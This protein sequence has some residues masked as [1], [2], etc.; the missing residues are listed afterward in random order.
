M[1]L[2]RKILA[3][4]LWAG[5]GVGLMLAA[6]VGCDVSDDGRPPPD[7]SLF[8][9]TG[10][11]ADPSGNL[12]YVTNGNTDLRFN[13]GSLVAIDFAA[14]L[15]A[16][17]DGKC[18]A[19]D[20]VATNTP[21]CLESRPPGG[22]GLVLA[23]RTVRI[24]SFA[25]Q[26]AMQRFFVA[27]RDMSGQPLGRRRSCTPDMSGM[28]CDCTA[29]IDDPDCVPMLD[30]D[31]TQG[32][33]LLI[34]V[35]GEPSLTWVNVDASGHFVCGQGQS[36]VPACDGNHRITSFPNDDEN[37]LPP[38]PFGVAV[39]EGLGVA[40]MAHLAFGTI[41]LFDVGDAP[42]S[43]PR[44]AYT[45][46]ETFAPTSSGARGVYGLAFRPFEGSAVPA[47]NAC[48]PQPRCS[49]ADFS[50]LYASSR[51]SARTGLL[52]VRGAEECR[53]A[54]AGDTCAAAGR[55]LSLV[56]GPDVRIETILAD[57]ADLRDVKFS[58]DGKHA[59]VLSRRPPSLLDIDTSPGGPTAAEPRNVVRQIIEVCADP[60]LLT[61]REEP[62]PTRIYVTCFAAGQVYVVD[63]NLGDVVDVVDVGR[64]PNGFTLV[65]GRPLR[66][67]V[68]NFAENNL[69]V[70]DLE[71]GSPTE[72]VVLFKIGYPRLIM[73]A[74]R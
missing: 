69:S 38:E 46:A 56:R 29:A 70:I 42:T 48:A 52:L 33:R 39:H 35:R 19:R 32:V 26:P 54:L 22:L 51:F 8:F 68:A 53:P 23:D 73:G 13:G 15:A 18:T 9:P 24:G 34:P 30:E 12:L 74:G 28:G 16:H 1:T 2:L 31:R 43:L 4:A 41:S 65:P 63:P 55:N 40:V 72:N 47:G 10:V 25:G 57:G 6:V 49:L 50:W 59:Y 7:D 37:L 71:P 44:L 64:G 11:V 21:V 3:K 5:F 27:R 14:A 67:V 66:G 20:P 36:P 45:N 58:A 17:R 60:S 61:V 62:G